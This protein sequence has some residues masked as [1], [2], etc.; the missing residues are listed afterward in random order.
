MTEKTEL[1]LEARIARARTILQRLQSDIESA[2]AFQARARSQRFT[3]PILTLVPPS[4]RKHVAWWVQSALKALDGIESDPTE[5]PLGS[6]PCEAVWRPVYGYEDRYEVS[7]EGQ[8]RTLLGTRSG[9][10]LSPFRQHRGYLYVTLWSE[11]GDR[12]HYPV[13]RLVIEAFTGP[14]PP[15]LQVAHT[16]GVPTDNRAE[17]L[18]WVTPKQNHDD[19]RRHGRMA[20]GEANHAAKLDLRRVDTIRRLRGTMTARDVAYLAQVDP[21]TIGDIWNGKT[22]VEGDDTNMGPIRGPE[23]TT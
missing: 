11:T 2:S 23:E 15:G 22:W 21:T 6:S 8:V 16:N 10:L 14:R 19:R 20:H 9:R 4:A 17:N 13:H 1:E 12:R 7:S 3:P 18:R 5:F